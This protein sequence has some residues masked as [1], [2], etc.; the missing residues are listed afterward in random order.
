MNWVEDG[1]GSSSAPLMVKPVPLHL[2]PGDTGDS[3]QVQAI[4][5]TEQMCCRAT[6]SLQTLFQCPQIY[7]PSTEHLCTV[8]LQQKRHWVPQAAP[9]D[10]HQGWLPDPGSFSKARRALSTPTSCPSSPS[11]RLSSQGAPTCHI[12]PGAAHLSVVPVLLPFPW[13]MASPMQILLSSLTSRIAAQDKSL[14]C[15]KQPELQ[16]K[17]TAFFMEFLEWNISSFFWFLFPKVSA[18]NPVRQSLT[19]E[20][21]SSAESPGTHTITGKYSLSQWPCTQTCNSPASS[22]TLRKGE[23]HQ[24]PATIQNLWPRP[25]TTCNSSS[26]TGFG[27]V[28][29]PSQAG[30]DQEWGCV[31]NQNLRTWDCR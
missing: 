7:L 17:E 2:C 21:F 6:L 23:R 26:C 19:E 18:R 9:W 13:M 16:S 31:I 4:L 11:L 10:W 27:N 29:L 8:I 30:C 20:S 12:P 5:P 22:D 14:S 15:P 28:L 25:R 24:F 1:P 3:E